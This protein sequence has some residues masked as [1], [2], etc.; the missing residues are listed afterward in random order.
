GFTLPSHLQLAC[1]Q[2][3]FAG[4][5][6]RPAVVRAA[7]NKPGPLH[8]NLPWHR[9]KL[10]DKRVLVGERHPGDMRVTGAATLAIHPPAPTPTM[11][12]LGSPGGRAS[13]LL[14]PAGANLILQS[15]HVS[16]A[17]GRRHE[18]ATPT[19]PCEKS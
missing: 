4:P 16:L 15:Q 9:S 12:E 2:A 1:C 11:D 8:S 5:S 18:S 17:C 19:P 13:A 10:G 7:Y 3:L 14:V 6:L